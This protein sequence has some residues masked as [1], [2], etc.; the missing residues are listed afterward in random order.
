[1]DTFGCDYGCKTVGES[2]TK[3]NIP[4]GWWAEF[5]A[6]D[7]IYPMI[8]IPVAQIRN[9]PALMGL[10]LKVVE[11]EDDEYAGC[12]VLPKK[13]T[14]SFKVDFMRDLIEAMQAMN[15]E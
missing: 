6:Y 10:K 1:M 9:A 15:R 14:I 7:D 8:C 12:I 4:D 3:Y 2:I 13:K 11:D 5:D